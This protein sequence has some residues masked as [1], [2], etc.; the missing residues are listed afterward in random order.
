[1]STW[2]YMPGISIYSILLA[3][4]SDP[5]ACKVRARTSD[6]AWKSFQL[7]VRMAVSSATTAF[8]HP[9]CNLW[10]SFYNKHKDSNDR[11]SPENVRKHVLQEYSHTKLAQWEHPNQTLRHP[12]HPDNRLYAPQHGA[13][14]PAP[15][16]ARRDTHVYNEAPQKWT[17]VSNEKHTES[18]NPIPWPMILVI[19]VA[20]WKF[21]QLWKIMPLTQS[22]IIPYKLPEKYE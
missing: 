20:C 16:R 13:R 17:K 21:Q 15:H 18:S 19:L 10:G 11:V 9:N 2:A 14:T 4:S 5:R 7:S 6:I 22:N 12:S 1:M 8:S 3:W